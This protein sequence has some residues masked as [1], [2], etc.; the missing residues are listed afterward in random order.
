MSIHDPVRSKID[1][2]NLLD[3]DLTPNP[4]NLKTAPIDLHR[5]GNN[6][7]TVPVAIIPARPEETQ[8]VDASSL[9]AGMMDVPEPVGDDP[10]ATLP[11][12]Y[13]IEASVPSTDLD[14]HDVVD[15]ADITDTSDV[16]SASAVLAALHSE[17]EPD[18]QV[19]QVIPPL[20]LTQPPAS[21]PP[22]PTEPPPP[23]V[24]TP[25][26]LGDAA[27]AAKRPA[28]RNP[29]PGPAISGE[30]RTENGNGGGSKRPKRPLTKV[31]FEEPSATP[32]DPQVASLKGNATIKTTEFPA[33]PTATIDAL[34]MDDVTPDDLKRPSK[35]AQPTPPAIP[36]LSQAETTQRLLKG[37]VVHEPGFFERYG[38]VLG[39]VTICL[40]VI[41]VGVFVAVW[42]VDGIPHNTENQTASL[43]KSDADY[44]SS[45][46]DV[47]KDKVDTAIVLASKEA[48]TEPVKIEPDQANIPPTDIDQIVIEDREPDDVDQS[49]PV[50]DVEITIEE[51]TPPIVLQ[52]PTEIRVL[53]DCKPVVGLKV[54]KDGNV[55]LGQK[56][57]DGKPVL[58]CDGQKYVA[59]EVRC[60]DNSQCSSGNL[61]PLDKK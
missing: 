20:P 58:M 14:A 27:N 61:I 47:A 37:A 28:N 22:A 44:I 12:N 41:L 21:P 32:S 9:A 17:D 10:D 52:T 19:N 46:V 6:G 42:Y 56:M 33:D 50:E 29:E 26:V 8:V 11:P 25:P 40:S 24:S 15:D 45:Q 53:K 4:S 5:M 1:P 49:P 39:I 38:T 35:D 43:T 51:E 55:V 2:E 23:K 34:W 59:E 48:D 13:A 16:V 3:S 7:V 54:D 18:T 31:H 30:S 57:Y 60:D 36:A